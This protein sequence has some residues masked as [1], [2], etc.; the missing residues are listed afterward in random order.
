MA[1]EV[2]RIVG[3]L[4]VRD[5][6]TGVIG[7]FNSAAQSLFGTMKDLGG[8]LGAVGG[9]LSSAFSG[10]ATGGP[11]GAALGAGAAVLGEVVSGIKAC[12]TEATSSE[13][14]WASLGA[15]VNRTGESW[16]ALKTGTE[17][18]LLSMSKLTTYSD[19]QLAQA[20]E[21]LMTFGLSYD[22]AMK[23]LGETIDF[24]AAKHMDL[25]SAAT[26]VGKAM[27]GNTAIL[28]RY[29]VDITTTKDQA[30][31]LAKE[32]DAAAKAIKAMGAGV[33]AWII[34]VTAA[35]GADSTFEAGLTTAKDKAAFL[36]E[37]F[38]QGAIDLPQFTTAMTSLG[39]PLD[40]VALKGGTAEA[41]LGKLNEQFG[42]AATAAAETYAGIQERLKNA[43]Q[44]VGEKIGTIFLP[45]LASLT[46]G[47]LPL[48]DNLGKAVDATS[49]WLTEVAKMPEVKGILDVLGPAF[50][51][52]GKY[53]G[54][55]WKLLVDQLGPA[56]TALL[57]AL[58]DLWDA[59]SPIGDAI[60][61]VLSAFGDTSNI[62][63]FKILIMT[64]VVQIQ[65]VATVIKD[66]APYI[67]AFAQGFKEAVDFITPILVQ[68]STGITG[69]LDAL[70]TAFQSFYTF[71]VGG[72]LWQDL[73]N[74]VLSIATSGIASLLAAVG[75]TF[76]DP[77]KAVFETAGAGIKTAWD[78]LWA[79]ITAPGGVSGAFDA[80]KNKFLEMNTE[81]SAALEE[82]KSAFVSK[83]GEIAP[84]VAPA[85][86]ALTAANKA[87]GDL[88]RG[89]M[90]GA[91]NDIQAAFSKGWKAIQ[92]TAQ[93]IWDAMKAASDTWISGVKGTID[94][95]MAAVKTNWDTV[96]RGIEALAK[97]VED[98]I[99]ASVDTWIK[100]VQASITSTVDTLK[101]AWDT[102]WNTFGSVLDSVFPAIQATV[103]GSLINPLT[104]KMSALITTV[105][106]AWA[107]TW[108]GMVETF[109]GL[110]SGIQAAVAGVWDP[111]TAYLQDAFANWGVW[112]DAA[113]TSIAAQS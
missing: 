72:S 51:S 75:T 17:A 4:Q 54:E 27:D 97:T 50:D 14:I 87:A 47:M 73:W 1:S 93:T 112:A 89:D 69:F 23:A 94:D 68:I 64:I 13:A 86:D 26:L 58:K 18:A 76:L 96:W 100:G 60:K 66:V 67:K 32:Q 61:E 82:L 6:A 16:T 25:E 65:A 37:Q 44:E 79:G 62:D 33:D 83:F 109:Q 95:T 84:G 111:L 10:F 107:N 30:A 88:M 105:Q 56:L 108:T 91:V 12:V 7:Q 113:M 52:L 70:R 38:K 31:E 35:I 11:A 45:A 8:S 92:T 2:G 103:T 49:A 80:I 57:G 98:S 36:V 46:E 3:V 9:V 20:L 81:G 5:E 22:E 74:S 90:Q 102:L 71:L 29:G 77:I 19:E 48:V 99:S 59:V 78:G 43:T 63:L 101:S 53:L 106:T 15:A 85:F 21:K 40:E 28:K 104:E 55:L 110:T 24:A 34:S 42:G 41:V 39:V